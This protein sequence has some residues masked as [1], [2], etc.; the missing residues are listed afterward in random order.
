MLLLAYGALLAAFTA[1]IQ[2][3]SPHITTR[4]ATIDSLVERGTF[5]ID[6][7]PYEGTVDKVYIDGRY[8]SHQPPAI[9]VVGALVYYPLRLFGMR[10]DPD[11][12]ATYV[13]LTLA[14]NGLSAMAGLVFFIRALKFTNLPQPLWLPLTASLACG[15]LLFPYSTTLT[16]HGICAGLL[17]I[18]LYC[19]LLSQESENARGAAFWSGMAFSLCAAADHA[20]LAFYG[21]FA[22]CL[23]MRPAR[24]VRALWFVLPAALT[25][26]PTFAY[27][28]AIGHSFKPFAARPELFAYPGSPW[29]GTGVST[30]RLTGGS[31]NPWPFA[32]SYG[33]LMLVGRRGFLIYNPT[34]CLALYGLT[35]SIRMKAKYWREAVAVLAGSAA[36]ITYYA[37]SSANFS[38]ASYSIRWFVP[39]LPLWW[40]FGSAAIERLESWTRWQKLVV[41]G[42]C[43]VSVCYAVAGALNPFPEEWHGYGM[44]LSNVLESLGRRLFAPW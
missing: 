39:L 7:S 41:A 10:L 21:L 3:M 22:A 17:A 29:A 12:P 4:L 26:V 32:V 35:R 28:H 40:F 34:S 8:Y 23:L 6:G 44:P 2:R 25:L 30:V 20:M 31:W 19:F 42:L 1:A 11:H 37:F 38:G 24:R 15:T 33:C 18:G 5:A 27:Y 16:S 13:L 14:L 9:A 43:A 36:V